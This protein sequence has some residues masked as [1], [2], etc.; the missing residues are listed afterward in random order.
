MDSFIK[1]PIFAEHLVRPNDIHP[2]F[3]HNYYKFFPPEEDFF[4]LVRSKLIGM[5]SDTEQIAFAFAEHPES[6]PVLEGWHAAQ[7]HGKVSIHP[8][9]VV[10]NMVISTEQAS[11]PFLRSCRVMQ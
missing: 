4:C 6:T 8:G 5:M 11:T 9:L 3:R 10:A 7:E 1:Y 2:H